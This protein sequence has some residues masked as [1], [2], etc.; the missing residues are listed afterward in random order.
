VTNCTEVREPASIKAYHC[1][2]HSVK[3]HVAFSQFKLTR[4]SAYPSK[5]AVL[6]GVP[7]SIEHDGPR[8]ELRELFP[9]ALDTET[10]SRSVP[11]SPLALELD[12]RRIFFIA[13]DYDS[14]DPDDDHRVEAVY[15]PIGGQA[16]RVWIEWK[17][18]EP[19]PFTMDPDPQVLS[20]ITAIANLL[21][22]RQPQGLRVPHC[23]GLFRDMDP[24]TG[25]DYC[26]FGLVF[27]FP[28]NILP[29][30]HIV[31]LLDVLNIDH[32]Q[33]PP[34]G[35][36]FNLARTI[37]EAVGRFHAVNWLHK[38]LR[39]AN[40]LLWKDST[41]IKTSD[42]DWSRPYISGFDCSRPALNDDMTETPPENPTR[43]I[44][45]HPRVQGT[46]TT[47][48]RSYD[49]YSLGII[50]LEI[51]YWQPIDKILKIG[52]VVNARPSKILR[53]RQR[54]ML[55]LDI[56][57]YV[58]FSCGDKFAD[59]TWKCIEGTEAFGIPSFYDETVEIGVALQMA[60]ND[61]VVRP[62]TD[63]AKAL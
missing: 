56:R 28:E 42:L 37:A 43:D 29:Q 39:S 4:E 41:K 30:E 58:R 63:L 31:S 9:A 24:D 51:G 33:P 25:E 46:G 20:R 5:S 18:F 1:W 12:R 48:K 6:L 26:R 40:I 27:E 61:Q 15:H 54:L 45:R 38:G 60:Y 44:Y 10:G 57:E 62:L 53:V 3:Y 36:R 13:C 47:Y 59:I 49:I 22:G 34:L 21:H 52:D 14:E 19:L 35:T 50:L 7:T 55:E 2:P 17:H 23:L 8:T 32:I 11:D 16:Q